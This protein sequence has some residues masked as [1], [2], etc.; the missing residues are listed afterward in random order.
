MFRLRS[1]HNQ[2]NL[3]NHVPQTFENIRY[4]SCGNTS[5][6]SPQYWVS[7]NYSHHKEYRSVFDVG[8]LWYSRTET[9]ANVTRTP[10]SSTPRKKSSQ[11][12]GTKTEFLSHRYR[13]DSNNTRVIL[14]KLSEKG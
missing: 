2:E 1:T 13:S 9:I 10:W 5:D 12:G 3:E 6:R 14:K 11:T 7:S 4:T 8:V